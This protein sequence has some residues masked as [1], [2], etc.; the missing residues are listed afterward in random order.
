MKRVHVALWVAITLIFIACD[1]FPT[2]SIELNEFEYSLAKDPVYVAY[3]DSLLPD[4]TVY[5]P[6]DDSTKV[7][8]ASGGELIPSEYWV[9]NL[10]D[11]SFTTHFYSNVKAVFHKPNSITI[12]YPADFE[13]LSTSDQWIG[14]LANGTVAAKAIR[15]GEKGSGSV[16]TCEGFDTEKEDGGSSQ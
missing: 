15:T 4:S 11:S 14:I 3:L 5:G 9:D 8:W 16:T 1:S 2:Q 6:L 10:C 7:Y 13:Y 12:A